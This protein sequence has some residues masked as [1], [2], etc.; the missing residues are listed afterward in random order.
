M[1]VS[2]TTDGVYYALIQM[3]GGVSLTE[4]T[5]AQRRQMY[6]QESG[7]FIASRVMA[8]QRFMQVVRHQNQGSAAGQD[9][10]EVMWQVESEDDGS[11]DDTPTDDVVPLTN[12]VGTVGTLRNELS[13]AL[14]RGHVRDAA[15]IQ[16]LVLLVLDNVNAG[17]MHRV[18][19][20][21][22]SGQ[23]P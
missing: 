14:G 20:R 3:G 21:S 15:E 23:P 19:E 13:H 8:Q 16:H 1:M 4:L 22:L 9:T 2:D 11:A 18:P 7:N 17:N 10:D 6:Q 5:P 12:L